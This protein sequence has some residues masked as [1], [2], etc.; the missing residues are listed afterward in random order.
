MKRYLVFLHDFRTFGKAKNRNAH[1]KIHRQWDYQK[2]D[3]A[4]KLA[5][6][7]NAVSSSGEASVS[8]SSPKI[9]F[10]TCLNFG[11]NLGSQQAIP[12]SIESTNECQLKL[13]EPA[14]VQVLNQKDICS[15]SAEPNRANM[16]VHV[17]STDDKKETNKVITEDRS[18]NG[19][20]AAQLDEIFS[21]LLCTNQ[22]VKTKELPVNDNN[23][24]EI[25][26]TIGTPSV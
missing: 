6:A 15:L 5:A 20:T 26:Q 13:S 19:P 24:R 2:I 11:L 23:I 22:D 25:V 17:S 16:N 1:K 3:Q 7:V 9:S 12:N 10:S 21:S 8:N 14:S 18:K 4:D